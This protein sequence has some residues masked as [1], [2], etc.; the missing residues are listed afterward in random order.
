MPFEERRTP[1]A[2]QALGLSEAEVALARG[3]IAPSVLVMASDGAIGSA[4]RREL[5]GSLRFNGAL[6]RFGTEAVVSLA[7]DM[8]VEMRMRF[9]V[10]T[11]SV[12]TEALDPPLRRTAVCM[13]LRIAMADGTLKDSEHTMLVDLAMSL[14]IPPDEYNKMVDVMAILQR[15]A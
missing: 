3:L 13:A 6:G 8:L 15:P 10:Q 11:L 2:G 5:I 1:S 14:D 4:E 12:L 7:E 9:G